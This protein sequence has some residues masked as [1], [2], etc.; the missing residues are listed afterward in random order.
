MKDT[1]EI[2]K[3]LAL[4]SELGLTMVAN[5]GVG[6]AIG[7]FLLDK[8]TGHFPAWTIV[9]LLLGIFSGFWSVYKIIMSKMK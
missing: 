8:K 4:V 9:F 5:I 1:P 6:F 7:Y 3:H 2:F